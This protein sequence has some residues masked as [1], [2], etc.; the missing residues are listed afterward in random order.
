MLN[1]IEFQAGP[2]QG[3]E[4]LKIE[5]T[6]LTVFVGPNNSGKS[7]SLSEIF[8]LIREPMHTPLVVKNISIDE[9]VAEDLYNSNRY[10]RSVRPGE[11]INEG[12]KLIE[13]IVEYENINITLYDQN[14]PEYFRVLNKR[15]NSDLAVY[16]SLFCLKLD[17][18]SRLN[19]INQQPA[20]D[21]LEPPRNSISYLFSNDEK[22]KIL[23]EIV[24]E[25]F[26]KYLVVD[27]TLTGNFRYRLSAT[28]PENDALEKGLTR[29][30]I[31]FHRNAH[32]VTEASDGVK[33][34]IGTL[35]T[36]IAGDPVLTLIDEPEAFLHPSLAMKLGKDIAR[37]VNDN[38]DGLKKQVIVST[39][40]ANFIMGCI[41]GGANINIVRLTYDYEN[42]TA[43]VLKRE[44]LTPLMRNPLLRSVGVLNALFYSAVIVTEADAD[45]AFYQEINE[46]L[47]EAKDRRG[48]EG[49]LFLNAQNKQTVW[50]IV[51]PLRKLGIPACGIVDLDAFNYTG[52]EFNKLLENC[53]IPPI[54]YSSLRIHKASLL[55]AFRKIKE[56]DGKNFKTEGGIDLLKADEKD[57]C[58]AFISTLA[59]YGAFIVPRGELEAWLTSLDVPRSKH[60]WLKEIFVAMG[61]D[62]TANS[63]VKPA[64]GDVWNFIATISTW[65]KNNN[66]KGIPA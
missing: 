57:A 13:K 7:K 44:Q 27:P 33:A 60:V 20:G 24:F 25:A 26:G 42:A 58:A 5:M 59:E 2:I 17:G 40:S 49:C 31:E 35:S 12:M 51:G 28:A 10:L 61:E 22:R 32:Q 8:Q 43:R 47:L 37:I 39:H 6:P 38:K 18:Q 54:M 19:L 15:Q 4:S 29:E 53:H 34:F 65:V 16:L 55:E 41:Q 50:D 21:L 56:N 45:R 1:E 14:K 3:A 9:N 36:L 64:N 62:P 52:G 11:Y 23:R 48:I 66:K 46:R 63:Y 30:S